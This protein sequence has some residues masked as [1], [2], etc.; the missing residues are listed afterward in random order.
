MAPNQQ[1]WPKQHI[2]TNVSTHSIYCANSFFLDSDYNS[3]QKDLLLPNEITFP[4]G[5][6]LRQ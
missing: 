2:V 3:G 6:F 5:T 1:T 4:S